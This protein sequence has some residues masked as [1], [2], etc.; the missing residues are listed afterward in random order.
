M[1]EIWIRAGARIEAKRAVLAL[2][3]DERRDV[4][5]DL[6]LECEPEAFDLLRRGITRAAC[7]WHGAYTGERTPCC[8][9]QSGGAP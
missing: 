7:I 2:S 4:I 3:K 1:S 9:H 8:V 6:L 5:L